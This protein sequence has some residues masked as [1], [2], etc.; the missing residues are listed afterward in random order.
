MVVV[1]YTWIELTV[2]SGRYGSL[3][4]CDNQLSGV[5]HPSIP[6]RSKLEINFPKLS[7]TSIAD[8]WDYWLRYPTDSKAKMP[9]ELFLDII[10]QISS[11]PSLSNYNLK[12]F[13]HLYINNDLTEQY[14]GQSSY[15]TFAGALINKR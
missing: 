3:M 6:L 12:I 13:H 7:R 9:K 2:W 5:H 4:F 11:E 14:L 8:N 10:T 1:G 15:L